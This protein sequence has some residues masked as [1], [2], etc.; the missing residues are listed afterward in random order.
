MSERR[1]S[2][3]SKRARTDKALATKML[4]QLREGKD[5]RSRKI[6]RIGASIRAGHYEND[7]KLQIAVERMIE[8]AH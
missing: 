5:A 8:S 3:T 2:T 1:Q 7:L 6:R 4:R